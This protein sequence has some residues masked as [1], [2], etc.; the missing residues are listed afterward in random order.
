MKSNC[1]KQF[2]LQQTVAFHINRHVAVAGNKS[3]PGNARID[4]SRSMAVNW[5]ICQWNSL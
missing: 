5:F 2:C 4:E 3:R 1:T